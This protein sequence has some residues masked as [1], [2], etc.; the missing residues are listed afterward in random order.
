MVTHMPSERDL[1]VGPAGWSYKDW[2]GIVY[3]KNPDPAFKPL[4]FIAEMFDT[5]EINSTFYHPANPFMSRAWVRKVSHNPRFLFTAKL[6]QRFTHDRRPFGS[7]EIRAV[8]EGIDPLAQSNRLGA[9]LCQFPWSYKNDENSRGWLAGLIDAF[10]EYPLVMEFRHSS[11]DSDS[12][13]DFLEQKGVSLASIDQPVIGRSIEPKAVRVGSIGY[14]R[15]HGRN[16]KAW[17]PSNKK[18]EKPSKMSRYDYLYSDTE[19]REWAD[20]IRFI[21]QGAKQTFVIQNNHPWGQ[22]VA[23]SLQLMEALG[24]TD[25]QAP[26]SLI[27]RYPRLRT[28]ARPS[29]PPACSP[30]A[31]S[32]RPDRSPLYPEESPDGQG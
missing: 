4:E 18:T 6:W 22:A 3:P 2:Q 5:V 23:N 8:R 10:R 29:P 13:H 20:K 19:I 9:V 15:L 30:R 16:Y 7:D 14:V 24:E 27:D 11:W 26:Q 12:I 25:I 21:H 32:R 17:F 28:I 31:D 1:Y